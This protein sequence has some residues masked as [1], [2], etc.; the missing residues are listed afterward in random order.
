MRKRILSLLNRWLICSCL[1]SS[2]DR[3]RIALTVCSLRTTSVNFCP[4]DPVP[5]VTRMVLSLSDTGCPLAGSDDHGNHKG[6]RAGSRQPNDSF[7]GSRAEL[8]DTAERAVVRRK[9]C[10]RPLTHRMSH[11]TNDRGELS[12]FL[13]L[14]WHA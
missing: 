14:L 12:K 4:N 2:R 9:T 5:P 13:G 8:R 11:F 7:W 3:M 10:S 6:D 1:S